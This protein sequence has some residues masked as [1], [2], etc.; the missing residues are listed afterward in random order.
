MVEVPR[1]VSA[2]AGVNHGPVIHGEQHGVRVALRL[3]VF[4][5]GIRDFM[6]DA[7]ASVLNQPR[8]GRDWLKR[9]R[10]GPG[11]RGRSNLEER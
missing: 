7:L 9:K 11:D 8:P 5:P 2:N 4:I 3:V 10:A 1:F 6:T